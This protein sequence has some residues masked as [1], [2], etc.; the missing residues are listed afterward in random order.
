MEVAQT[1]KQAGSLAIR[2]RSLPSQEGDSEM[3]R[4]ILVLGALAMA[5]LAS[6]ILSSAGV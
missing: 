6:L 5:A 3:T 2:P 1:P 4:A